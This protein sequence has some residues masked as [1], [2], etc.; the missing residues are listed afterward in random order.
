[1]GDGDGSVNLDDV[2]VTMRET[3]AAMKTCAGFFLD[4]RV[5][6]NRHYKETSLAGLA[7]HVGDVEC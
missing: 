3:G 6:L 5:D 1:M 4:L 2:L 7:I